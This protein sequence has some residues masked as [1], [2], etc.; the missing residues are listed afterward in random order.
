MNPYELIMM[1]QQRMNNDPTFAAK[2]TALTNELNNIPGLQQEVMK[3]AQI[4]DDKKRQKAIDRL[5]SKVKNTVREMFS[6]L[7]S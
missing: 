2:F 1:I 3:I 7:N 6:L 5:P 4:N